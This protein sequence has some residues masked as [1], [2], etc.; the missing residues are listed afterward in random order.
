[1][2]SLHFFI[3]YWPQTVENQSKT[4]KMHLVFFEETDNSLLRLR[5]KARDCGPKKLNLLQSWRNPQKKLESITSQLFLNRNERTFRIFRRIEHL[6]SSIVWRVMPDIF[7]DFCGSKWEKSRYSQSDLT[8]QLLTWLIV[9]FFVLLHG[10]IRFQRRTSMSHKLYRN[11]HW[12]RVILK[13]I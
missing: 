4:P 10:K 13:N 1:M 7:Q 5:P 9:T 2:L 12:L 8:D 3:I 11:Y 6:S